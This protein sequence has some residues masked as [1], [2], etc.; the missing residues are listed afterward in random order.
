LHGLRAPANAA[1]VY[2]LFDNLRQ[3]QH[4]TPM[5]VQARLLKTASP[6]HADGA[7]HGA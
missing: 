5:H 2:G 3:Q 6:S 4:R 7:A 1:A